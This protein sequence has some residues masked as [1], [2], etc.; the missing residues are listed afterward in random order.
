[1][2]LIRLIFC[3]ALACMAGCTSLMPGPIVAPLPDN[4][5]S[6][7]ERARLALQGRFAVRYEDAH[8]RTKHAYGH[9]SWAEKENTVTLELNNPLGQTLA[10]ITAPRSSILPPTAFVQTPSPIAEQ[11]RI[12]W[13]NHTAQTADSAEL[14]MQKTL[15]FTIPLRPLRQVLLEMTSSAPLRSI[16]QDG[17]VVERMSRTHFSAAQR[18]TLEHRDPP[19]VHVKLII[20]H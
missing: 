11:A 12:E 13:P 16:E 10:I 4:F 1:M 5:A 17:W 7:P 19:A 14:L 2:R 3:G 8:Y 9:F 15:G 18:F 6:T 20:T